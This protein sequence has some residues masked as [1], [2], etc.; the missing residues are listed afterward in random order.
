M[1]KL[2]AL[3]RTEFVALMA[4]LTALDALAIDTMLPALSQMSS[5]LN[6][7]RD[8]D[9][10]FIIT[11]IFL[12]FAMGLSFYGILGDVVGRRKPVLLGITIFLFGTFI[13]SIAQDLPTMI[14]GRAIQGLGAAG[15]YVLSVAIV[16]DVYKGRSM[17]QTMSLIFMIFMV[18][19]AI[20]PL[21]GQGILLFSDWRS[22]F[23]FF[24][25]FGTI[26]F[27][28]FF[29]RQPETLAVEARINLSAN[30]I[31]SAAREVISHRQ[32]MSY[33][34]AQGCIFGSFV[35]YLSTAQQ[36]FQGQYGLGAKFP[37]YFGSL[38]LLIAVASFLNSRLVMGLGMY[39]LVTRA[40]FVFC[41]NSVVFLV[42]EFASEAGLPLWAF[43]IYMTTTYCCCGML[44]GNIT[45]M[46]MEPMGHIAGVA[47]AVT[48]FTNTIVAILLGGFIGSLYDNTLMPLIAGF[49]VLPAIALLLIY[50][51][52][53]SSGKTAETNA[54][55]T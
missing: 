5:D 10:Q 14:A 51:G 23:L 48:G 52:K 6:L 54:E 29:L 13:S 50:S 39:K 28:W 43:M 53:N 30:H 34:V 40:L 7:T 21:I 15:P 31:F 8:N 41:I 18:I 38:A 12:G 37:I 3:S 35:T 24:G 46:A 27:A 19:P 9:R 11:S 47:S 4:C 49:T 2:T 20:A 17:A 16:R 45:S 22:I 36:V 33:T 44:F 25:I 1:P 42:L 26:V 32:V 55:N